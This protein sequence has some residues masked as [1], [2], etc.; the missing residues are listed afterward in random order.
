MGR[1]FNSLLLLVIVVT[2]YFIMGILMRMLGHN[3]MTG[4]FMSFVRYAWPPF[5]LLH[6]F[7]AGEYERF[8]L[9]VGRFSVTKSVACVVHS[10]M[11]TVVYSVIGIVLLCRREFSRVRD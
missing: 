5:T 11:L 7:A 1:A 4:T 10:L 3:A 2:G 9:T 6:Q 8:A